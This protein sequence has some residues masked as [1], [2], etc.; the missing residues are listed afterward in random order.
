MRGKNCYL[1][2]TKTKLRQKCTL[3]KTVRAGTSTIFEKAVSLMSP[4]KSR[5]VWSVSVKYYDHCKNHTSASS[6]RTS[7]EYFTLL[8][9]LGSNFDYRGLNQFKKTEFSVNVVVLNLFLRQNFSSLITSA[10]RAGLSVVDR[11]LSPT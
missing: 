8:R 3:T 5:Y 6:Q 1:K 10:S 4:N 9:N 2:L 11:G 7:K